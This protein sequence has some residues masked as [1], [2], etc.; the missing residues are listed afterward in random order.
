MKYG[1]LKSLYY[2]ALVGLHSPMKGLDSLLPL[3]NTPRQGLCLPNFY[4]S[5][6]IIYLLML[7][8]ANIKIVYLYT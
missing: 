6:F 1:G 7:T 5:N 2:L 8:K 4:K 3:K